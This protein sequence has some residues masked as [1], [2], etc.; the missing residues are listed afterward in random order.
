MS[1]FEY[2]R[3]PW[4][5]LDFYTLKKKE[6]IHAYMRQIRTDSQTGARRGVWEWKAKRIIYNLCPCYLWGDKRLLQECLRPRAQLIREALRHPGRK[7]KKTNSLFIFL[8]YF[9]SKKTVNANLRPE[10]LT[11]RTRPVRMVCKKGNQ[12]RGIC[13]L[14]ES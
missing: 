1:N 6:K 8:F 4:L 7:K 2:F 14:G 11:F 5:S 10:I 3:N 9:T 13:Y 12:F